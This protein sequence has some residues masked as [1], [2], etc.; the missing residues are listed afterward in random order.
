M[1]KIN[2]IRSKPSSSSIVENVSPSPPSL[3]PKSNKNLSSYTSSGDK[4]V[5]L[6]LIRKNTL[7]DKYTNN[8]FFKMCG[9]NG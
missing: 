7:R 8:V 5:C 3:T 1:I 9:L 6:A 4:A 2:E